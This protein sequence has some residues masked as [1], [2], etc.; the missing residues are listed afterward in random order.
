MEFFHKDKAATAWSGLTCILRRAYSRSIRLRRRRGYIYLLTPYL[1]IYNV[2]NNAFNNSHNTVLN[3]SF[4]TRNSKS[5]KG[6]KFLTVL[7]HKI[8]MKNSLTWGFIIHC[9]IYNLLYVG[10]VYFWRTEKHVGS[11]PTSYFVG[12]RFKYH[13]PCIFSSFGVNI[14]TLHNTKLKL[15]PSTSPDMS[16]INKQ[17]NKQDDEL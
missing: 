17:I 13:F 7:S 6:E 4:R 5:I 16:Q 11:T 2:F 10:T 15:L 12:L 9:V 14:M 8:L 3:R 1:C